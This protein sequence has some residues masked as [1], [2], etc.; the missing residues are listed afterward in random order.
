M[1]YSVHLHATGGNDFV[2][3]DEQNAEENNSNLIFRRESWMFEHAALDH[4][5]RCGNAETGFGLP[6]FSLQSLP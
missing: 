2:A 6:T 5:S 3:T 4:G 1:W